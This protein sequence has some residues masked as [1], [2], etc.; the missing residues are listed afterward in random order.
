M[1]KAFDLLYT[2]F[3]PPL[4]LLHGDVWIEDSYPAQNRNRL[5]SGRADLKISENQ[6]TFPI[7]AHLLRQILLSTS[8]PFPTKILYPHWPGCKELLT[9]PIVGFRSLNRFNNTIQPLAVPTQSR[10]LPGQQSAEQSVV[11]W[12]LRWKDFKPAATWE[13]K[14][15]W[16]VRKETPGRRLRRKKSMI[17]FD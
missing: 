3:S 12:A 16:M 8:L 2:P 14:W 1:P 13:L 10:G 4:F 11:R 6:D 15:F 5:T 17:T 7:L 9:T